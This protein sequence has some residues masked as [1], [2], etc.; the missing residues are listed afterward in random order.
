MAQENEGMFRLGMASLA[1][2][3]R[4][5]GWRRA[6]ASAT[7]SGPDEKVCGVCPGSAFIAWRLLL[8]L[9]RRFI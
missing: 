5:A 4:R 7:L 2:A 9:K 6:P 1:P 8:L 3:L